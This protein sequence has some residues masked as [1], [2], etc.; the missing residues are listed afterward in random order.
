M[1]E[2][3][4]AAALAGRIQQDCREL[5]RGK[6]LQVLFHLA[7]QERAALKPANS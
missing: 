5:M 7:A 6:L 1:G 4:S 3:F 2:N